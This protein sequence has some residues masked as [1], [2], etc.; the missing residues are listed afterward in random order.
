MSHYLLP[1]FFT[2][3]LQSQDCERF[4]F[5][6]P[7]LNQEH[8]AQRFQWK[9]LPQGM[10]NSPT[11]CQFFVN[12]P[13]EELRHMYP[14]ARILHYMDDI[15]FAHPHQQTLQQMLQQAEL[16]FKEWGLQ[17]APE[18]IQKCA[19][20]QYLGQIVTNTQIIPQKVQI[21]RDSLVTL[22]DFQK[23]LGD[24]NWLRPSLGIPTY[25]LQNLFHTLEG[26]PA[27][28]SYRELSPQAE[29]ELKWIEKH[30]H[31]A[32]LD[33]IESLDHLRLI[34]FHTPH[35]PTG[36]LQ[37]QD[38][39]I[40]WIFL[41][42]KAQKKLQSYEQKIADIIIKGRLRLRQTMWSGPT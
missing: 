30:I 14:E 35:S 37:Q 13:L 32:Q 31:D 28:N 2:I 40:E 9:V 1:C 23:L 10:L 42:H 20:W 19:P 39:L 21:R 7:A 17:I 16:K 33:R 41:A 29:Q 34:V 18:K 27:L 25:K 36:L 12:Q 4:A 15:L 24:I 26:D 8:P 5:T 3:P 6:V 38:N 11:M 22:N